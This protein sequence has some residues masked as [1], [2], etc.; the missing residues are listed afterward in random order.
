M[1]T[2]DAIPWGSET[3]NPRGPLAGSRVRSIHNLA[4]ERASDCS[5][6][7]GCRDGMRCRSAA[8]PQRTRFLTRLCAIARPL[9]SS[10]FPGIT[11][12]MRRRR[13]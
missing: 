7:S 9:I 10:S 1:E 13:L 4:E 2:R 11:N 12:L 6:M 3:T 5:A 8:T